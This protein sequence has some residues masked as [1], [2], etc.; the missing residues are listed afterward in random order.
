MRSEK[1]LI[2]EFNKRKLS[3]ILEPLQGGCIGLHHYQHEA[4]IIRAIAENLGYCI[5]K[6]Y[7]YIDAFKVPANEVDAIPNLIVY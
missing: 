1:N 6:K 5:L 7:E 4:K 2:H 3:A